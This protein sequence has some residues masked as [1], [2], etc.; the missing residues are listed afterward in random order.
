MKNLVFTICSMNYLGQALTLGDSLKRTNPDYKFIIGLVDRI[1]ERATFLADNTHEIIEIEK[2]GVTDFKGMCT[3]YT[4]VELNTAVKPYFAEYLMNENPD[5]TNFSYLDPDMKVFRKLKPLED[6][7]LKYNMVLTPHMTSSP[8]DKLTINE[9]SVLGVGV[10]N[11][12]FIGMKRSEETIRFLRW[13]QEKLLHECIYDR[14]RNV[15]VDQGWVALAPGY[16]DDVL[17]WR[18]KGANTAYW[19][20]HDRQ[21]EKQGENYLINNDT[22]LLFFHFS[23]YKPSLP[24]FVKKGQARITFENRPDIVDLF[25]D[26]QNELVAN[27]FMELKKLTC[28]LPVNSMNRYPL[29]ERIKGKFI[30]KI[31]KI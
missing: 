21:F 13:W 18:H 20:L 6:Q 22:D 8:K 4:I 7:L 28:K 1:E 29:K 23:G 12:G 24:E 26:Y 15:N 25:K 11:L 10:Y 19:N 5:I 31:N 2:I 30:S 14:Q 3:R 27:Q 16:F 17:V 9:Y